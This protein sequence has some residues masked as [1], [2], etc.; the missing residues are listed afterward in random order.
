MEGPD[1]YELERY[2][3]Q[4]DLQ[5]VGKE[6][7]KKLSQAKVLIIGIGGLGC[8][9]AQYLVAAGIGNIG[10]MDHDKVSLS[11]LQR[12]ILFGE[13]DLEKNKAICAQKKLQ[14]LNSHVNYSVFPEALTPENALNILKDFD[15]VIDGT[16][17]FETKYLINDATLLLEKPMVFGSVYKFE[18]QLSTFNYQGGPS[19]R[20]IFPQHHTLDPNSCIDTGVIGILPGIVGTMQAM[21]AIKIILDIGEVY[22]GKMKIFNTLTNQEQIV[23]FDR[24][25][26]EI[27]QVLEKGLA[28]ES[29]MQACMSDDTLYIDVR[30]FDE[31][32][33][34]SH[35]TSL[36]IPLSQLES[37]LNEIPREQNVILFCQTGKRSQ[38]ALTFLKQKHGFDNLHHL[39]GGIK[40]LER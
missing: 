5:N 33:E 2:Q 27:Q 36:R 12:Q 20:C 28:T 16:D 23:S 10:L 9:A 11:N 24:N 34:I 14:E 18:G 40:E 17:N 25:E 6:G 15:L 30:E 35:I 13:K 3:R 4:T 29:N 1:Q 7:Q 39:N 21:E 37:R 8:P 22:S 38:Q 19:Y 32:P 26:S 31:L